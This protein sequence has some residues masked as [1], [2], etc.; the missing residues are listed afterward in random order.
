MSYSI[1]E[2]RE[3]SRIINPTVREGRNP[4]SPPNVPGD[5][6]YVRLTPTV[7]VIF[8]SRPP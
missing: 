6:A 4:G 2:I 1:A 5:S 3:K 7:L 8:D